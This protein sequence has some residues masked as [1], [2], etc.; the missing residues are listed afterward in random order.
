MP[1]I[2][3]IAID[4][5]DS[6]HYQKLKQPQSSAANQQINIAAISTTAINKAS[7]L[8]RIQR[9]FKHTRSLDVCLDCQ[10]NVPWQAYRLVQTTAAT[11]YPFPMG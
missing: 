9:V 11:G 6:N 10:V 5:T 2:N 7:V 8:F 4:A 1:E 3:T